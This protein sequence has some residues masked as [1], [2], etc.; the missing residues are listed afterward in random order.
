[1]P[2][3]A[4]R[5]RRSEKLAVLGVVVLKVWTSIEDY[6]DRHINASHG[7]KLLSEERDRKIS[8]GRTSM[9]KYALKDDWRK[10]D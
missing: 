3:L 4:Q 10:R 5:D 8:K 7:R 9:A 1:M 2:R 6:T